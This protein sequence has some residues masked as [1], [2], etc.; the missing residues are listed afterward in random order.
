LTRYQNPNPNPNP[1]PNPNPNLNPNPDPKVDDDDRFRFCKGDF[2]AAVDTLKEENFYWW[3]ELCSEVISIHSTYFDES[4][5]QHLPEYVIQEI[6]LWLPV[7]DFH[8][9]V[10]V[11]TEWNDLGTRDEVWRTFYTR[12]FLHFN[13]NS[14]PYSQLHLGF[15]FLFQIRLRSPEVGDRVEVAWRG[16]FR[17]EENEV[18]QGLAWWVAEVVDVHAELDRYKIRYLGWDTQ[19]DDWIPR[20]RLRWAV[21]SNVVQKIRPGDYVELWCVGSNV[22]GAWLETKVK[23]VSKGGRYFLDQEVLS[24]QGNVW[25]RRDRLRLVKRG[26]RK[27]TKAEKELQR[28]NSE[29]QAEEQERVSREPI[30]VADESRLSFPSLGA[31]GRMISRRFSVRS[32]NSE[33]NLLQAPPSP[34]QVE[35]R[36]TESTLQGN[37]YRNRRD[38]DRNLGRDDDHRQRGSHSERDRARDRALLGYRDRDVDGGRGRGGDRERWRESSQGRLGDPHDE[39]YDNRHEDRRRSGS[40]VRVVRGSSMREIVVGDRERR[41][42]DGDRGMYREERDHSRRSSSSR[43]DRNLSERHRELSLSRRH[44]DGYG[45][46]G[47]GDGGRSLSRRPSVRDP[48][49]DDDGYDDRHR[50]R[51][52]GRSNRRDRSHSHRERNSDRDW[53]RD[54]HH[55]YGGDRDRDRDHDRD[56]HYDHNH[57]RQRSPRNAPRNVAPLRSQTQYQYGDTMGPDGYRGYPQYTAGP[58]ERLRRRDSCVLM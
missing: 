7:D 32:E 46:G 26:R 9:V 42:S 49:S 52:G 8:P 43:L 48:S 25:V 6:M 4:P 13:P 47:S 36:A 50:D 24:A 35:R 33:S 56:Y 37:D 38:R 14:L 57:D 39:P 1:D 44:S 27:T 23:K 45:H 28:I 21:E 17:L 11:C 41:G 30:G 15:R 54:R 19:W 22:P 51:D 20:D 40:E 2:F 18:Y 10:E 31:V 58:R 55:N 3:D 16:K 34:S 12:K 53:D 5:F 29:R